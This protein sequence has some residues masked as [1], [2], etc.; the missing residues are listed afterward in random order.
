[1]TKKILIAMMA[2]PSLL[3]CV[4]DT[5]LEIITW[6]KPSDE[7]LIEPAGTPILGDSVDIGQTSSY[8]LMFALRN[9]LQT[10]GNPEFGTVNSNDVEIEEFE[11]TLAKTDTASGLNVTN[12]PFTGTVVR[13]ANYPVLAGSTNGAAVTAWDPIDGANLTLANPDQGGQIVIT[14]KA[15]GHLLDDTTVES[16]AATF[17]LNICQGCLTCPTGQ[18][19]DP[20]CGRA[21]GHLWRCKAP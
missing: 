12:L 17:L 2:V 15:R 1:M 14:I 9:N 21:Q 6:L 10:N 5:S 16:N 3:S 19:P 7:C 18:V 4:D 11:V 20:V 13:P 8:L